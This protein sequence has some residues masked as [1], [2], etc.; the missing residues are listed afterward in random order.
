MPGPRFAACLALVLIAVGGEARAADA[1]E[2]DP[3]PPA[4]TPVAPALEA[5]DTAPTAAAPAPAL[6][7]QPTF[8]DPVTEPLAPRPQPFYRKPWFWGGVAAL[9]LTAAIVGTLALGNGEAPTPR[10]TLGDM[11]AF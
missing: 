6:E 5:G 9:C 1:P 11:H 7:A 8:V 10:T 4:I 3:T 2:S